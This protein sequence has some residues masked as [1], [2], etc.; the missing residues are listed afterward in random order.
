MKKGQKEQ[1]AEVFQEEDG[2]GVNWDSLL[3][4]V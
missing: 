1:V 2:A 3:V 4:V